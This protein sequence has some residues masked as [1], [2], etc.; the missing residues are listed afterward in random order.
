MNNVMSRRIF[1]LFP[2]FFSFISPFCSLLGF[3]FVNAELQMFVFPLFFLPSVTLCVPMLTLKL[4]SKSD[5]CEECELFASLGVGESV[6]TFNRSKNVKRG[7]KIHKMY[8][9]N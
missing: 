2:F 9:T 4:Q 5:A 3:Y 1:L 7:V 6:F 8:R